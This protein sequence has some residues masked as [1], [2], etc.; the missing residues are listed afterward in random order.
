MTRRQC[1]ELPAVSIPKGTTYG[2]LD[3]SKAHQYL[4]PS[5]QPFGT[6]SENAPGPNTTEL[7]RIPPGQ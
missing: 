1:A 4:G 7:Q 6:D 2:N 3:N 5:G